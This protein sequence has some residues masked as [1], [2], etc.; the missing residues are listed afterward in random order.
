MKIKETLAIEIP[1]EIQN[2]IDV[3]DLKEEVVESEISEYIV[4][5]KLSK[6]LSTLI[7]AY[8][9][10]HKE[11]GVWLSG[12]Y[13]SGK[14]YFAK[15]FGQLL[16]N[17]IIKGTFFVDRFAGRIQGLDNAS[18]L[19]NTVRGLSKYKTKLV[20][21]DIGKKGTD[22]KS[23]LSYTLFKSFLKSLG[24]STDK[25]GYMEFYLYLDGEY[26]IFKEAV[27]KIK[28]NDWD[29]IRK[30]RMAVP[31]I[32]AD[33]LKTSFPDKYNDESLKALEDR[34]N[35]FNSDFLVEE[36]QKFL[37][38]NKTDRIVFIMDEVSEAINL[39]KIDFLDL[40]A[41]TESLSS[42]GAGKVW[43]I[44]CAQ[45]KLDDV[46]RNSKYGEN[47]LSKV[48]DR[49][50]TRIHLSSEEVNE[51][52]EKR[53]LKKNTKGHTYLK[54]FYLKN[55][56]V[57]A[58]MTNLQN[59]TVKTKTENVEE[60]ISCYPFHKFQFTLMA[61]FLFKM[62]RKAKSGGTERGMIIAFHGVMK[63][64]KEKDAK[65]F[66][67]AWQLNEQGQKN[68]DS[69]LMRKYG[70]SS[71]EYANKEFG[72]DGS[73]ILKVINFLNESFEV[74]ATIDNITKNLIWDIS[75]YYE[76]KPKVEEAIK[77]LENKNL[78]ISKQGKFSISSDVEAKLLE[79]KGKKHIQ[80]YQRKSYINTRLKELSFLSGFKIVNF[81]GNQFKISFENEDD[82][83]IQGA[84][85]AFIKLGL[86]NILNIE[87]KDE[88]IEKQKFS[89]QSKKKKVLIVPELTHFERI[90]SLVVNI[91]QY[92]EMEELY[93][94]D[95]DE[96]VKTV[97]TDF[98]K[99]RQEEE[100]TVILLLEK[101]YTNGILVQG[102]N[103]KNITE[104][105][106]NTVINES[107]QEAISNTFT[108]LL[109]SSL[110]EE[111]SKRVLKQHD[112]TKLKSLF[113]DPEFAFFDSS[114]NFV[115]SHLKVIEELTNFCSSYK[116][117]SEIEQK[118][119]APPYGW[120]YGTINAALSVLMRAGNLK[121]KTDGA[122]IFD[123]KDD[124]ERVIKV[125][126]N[127]TK[128]KKSVFKTITKN[129]DPIQKQQIVENLNR[130]KAKDIV[131]ISYNTHTNDIALVDVLKKVMSKQ[132]TK[133][134]DIKDRIGAFAELEKKVTPEIMVLLDFNLA[135]DDSNFKDVAQKY[136]SDV[137]KYNKA[138][139]LVRDLDDFCQEKLE[140]LKQMTDFVSNAKKQFEKAG[141][142][143]TE[144]DALSKK[145]DENIKS[146]PSENYPLLNE[147]HQKIC[148]EYFKA[149][150]DP[151]D[152]V[153][154]QYN[155]I[156]KLSGDL[157]KEAEKKSKKLNGEIIS[158][159]QAILQE[160]EKNI[161]SDLKITKQV[162]CDKC[163][164]TL[165]E[166]LMKKDLAPGREKELEELRFK[167]RDDSKKEVHPNIEIV[168]FPARELSIE[169]YRAFLKKELERIEK[170]KDKQTKFIIQKED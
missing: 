20:Y 153:T 87:N 4:T 7:D 166:V 3:Q 31:K 125:F 109:P 122:E 105:N 128:F 2:V 86:S 98:R 130:I 61:N 88:F 146:D 72:F 83:E 60:F 57:I 18:I 56:G 139:G 104:D 114:G 1:D 92:K 33:V 117:G 91:L 62:N 106:Y 101:A 71:S 42:I 133:Y 9:K 50:K 167:I 52:I 107:L 13:G 169:S 21:L 162:E 11:T 49:F 64:I 75:S 30:N 63:S 152:Q 16:E 149:Y 46:I 41:V 48:Q 123:Y 116:E 97:I 151:H 51:V 65:F 39:E 94:S 138:V 14:S 69:D 19:E 77:V 156:K 158:K 53:L 27:K 5:E 103:E 47:E 161:C 111:I 170:I 44:A 168:K 22:V 43:T 40:Q 32:V 8:S 112:A 155:K 89:L 150:K 66:V 159:A 113:S 165:S 90:N 84:K 136:L 55:D 96:R 24:F 15:V 121:V 81:K 36:I 59:S 26:D 141:I 102:F 37:N 67:T 132:H 110:D 154:K 108:D 147:V 119:T 143:F 126:E 70:R 78:I 163:G 45:E 74:D 135:I 99:N 6:H 129:L 160:A 10:T 73:H 95:S 28:G 38:I 79:D 157:I 120:T 137:D 127:S 164:R 35:H 148:D 140:K 142:S 131:E 118:Y 144:I 12:F 82:D 134:Q 58:E 85:G 25:F 68:P 54:D 80:T 115:G 124:N 93:A 23:G 29:E 145:W 34:I 17:N 100:K 76:L